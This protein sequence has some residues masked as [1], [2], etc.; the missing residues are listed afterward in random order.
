[1]IRF[2]RIGKTAENASDYSINKTTIQMLF[3]PTTHEIKYKAKQVTDS[4]MQRIGDVGSAIVVFLGTAV[5]TF[6]ARGFAALNLGIILI[7]LVVVI[8]IVREHA[9]IEKGN[10]PEIAGQP[11]PAKQ[12]A[13]S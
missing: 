1:L 3:L 7:W 13:V 8:M 4:F 5:F 11:E 9:E 10:R 12:S 2:A 6:G